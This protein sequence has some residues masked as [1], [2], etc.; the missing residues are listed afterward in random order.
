MGGVNNNRPNPRVERREHFEGEQGWPTYRLSFELV[1]CAEK[2]LRQALHDRETKVYRIARTHYTPSAIG[3]IVMVTNALDAFLNEVCAYRDRRPLATQPLAA[4]LR[5][6]APRFDGRAV[7]LLGLARNEIAHYLPRSL[8][9]E[10]HL[11]DALAEWGRLGLLMITPTTRSWVLPQRLASYA[12]ALW[13]FEVV[14]SAIQA[15]VGASTPDQWLSTSM[16]QNF[17][18][19]RGW[20]C[21]IDQLPEYDRLHALTL[22]ET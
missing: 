10:G 5:A 22:T 13:A 20:A 15:V 6:L 18:L 14:E 3:A 7:D 19:F 21:P 9:D 4:K 8:P 11:A 1:V 2:L 17:S 12:L 16:A